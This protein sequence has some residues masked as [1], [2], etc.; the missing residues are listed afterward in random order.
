[1]VDVL[2]L[3]SPLD[4]LAENDLTDEAEV[5]SIIREALLQTVGDT[6]FANGKVPTWSAQLAEGCLKK[7]AALQKPFKYVVTV[8]LCQKAGAGLH[9]ASSAR[10]NPKTDGKLCVHW[11]SAT[12]S[13]L[14]VVYW[15]AV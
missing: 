5:D 9:A 14:V 1:M 10:W 6:P 11:E 7:L 12:V 15:V 4:G 3:N 8:N 2:D 13:A